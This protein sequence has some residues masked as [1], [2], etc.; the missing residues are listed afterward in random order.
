MTPITIHIRE[1]APEDSL[2]ELTS[3]INRAYA[4]VAALGYRLAGTYQDV[5]QTRHRVA[6]GACFVAVLDDTLVGTVTICPGFPN[7]TCAY[8]ARPNLAYR[9]QFAVEERLQRHGIGGMLRKQASLW[10]R[11]YGFTELGADTAEGYTEQINA[12][13]KEGFIKV[14][15]I[16]WPGDDF[17]STVLACPL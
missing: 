1:L 5:E 9:F 8:L 17:H 16:R 7:E 3:L 15:R 10:A 6:R 2:E 4:R 12:M 13:T 11:N 14:D